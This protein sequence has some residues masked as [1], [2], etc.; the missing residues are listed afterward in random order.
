MFKKI[1]YIIISF[2]CI[3]IVFKQCLSLEKNES[4]AKEIFYNGNRLLVSID[5]KESTTLPT[6]GTYYL[7]DYNCESAET[8]LNWNVADYT[9]EVSNSNREGGVSCNL[10]FE[11]IPKLSKMPVGSY[12]SYTGNNN[13]S[14]ES[15]NGQN[16][17]YASA[18]RLGYCYSEHYQ[19][20][21]EGWRLA[22]SQNGNAYIISAGATDCV[23]T[24]SS[25]DSSA[26]C[27]SSLS[28]D[29]IDIILD[30]ID[31]LSLTYCNKDYV[32][33]GV[34]NTQVARTMNITDFVNITGTKLI[35]NSS[36]DS[37]CYSDSSSVS[38]GYTNDLIDNGGYYWYANIPG[39]LGNYI[40]NWNPIYRS[41]RSSTSSNALG[42]RPVI[43]LDSNVV[44]TG[45]AGTAD[46]PYTIGNNTFWINNGATSVSSTD[47][48]TLSL[49]SVNAAT[50][51]ISTSTSVCT[52][53]VN[54]ATSYILDWSNEAA[55]EKVVYVYYKN[56]AGDIIAT[57][58]QSVTLTS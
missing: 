52:N 12:I 27:N 8:V 30:Y 26:S 10:E 35:Y 41:V 39:A 43:E 7:I 19:F 17:N 15:C 11:S 1:F 56:N 47:T 28:A 50:M 14:G 51:C 6:S 2:F 48:I 20:I 33:G 16:A 29:D 22:Y 55:G 3:L 38:C 40:F 32:N 24:N 45:G 34:C 4:T 57:M 42:V 53:Y 54:F 23:C 21:A 36:S 58:K 5:G 37:S 9:L 44:V 46:N 25:G 31:E 13:C 18:G 49:M